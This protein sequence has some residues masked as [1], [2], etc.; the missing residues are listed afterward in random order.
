M[1]ELFSIREDFMIA[2]SL[3][4]KRLFLR[5][6]KPSDLP[7]FAEMN[8]DPRVMRHFPKTLSEEESNLLAKK[9]I[10]E[11]EKNPYGLWAVEAF[12]EAPFIGF[13]GLHQA[14][15]ATHFT[16]CVEIGWRLSYDHWK[17]GYAFEAASRVLEYAF[18]TLSMEEIVSFTTK[19]NV[20]SENL[21]KKLGMSYR[22]EDDFM[23]PNIP[24]SSPLCS[25][26]LYR[27]SKETF[28][29]RLKTK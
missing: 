29:K 21:M 14:S 20:R 10:E 9:L 12:G 7:L 19:T 22:Q 27:M 4:T 11:L 26:V 18:Q 28:Q 24:S 6:W 1:V 13:V 17:K 15:F 23:H 2:P 16:P 5:H 3:S 25:H 8:S